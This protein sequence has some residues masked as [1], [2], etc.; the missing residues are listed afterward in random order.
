MLKILM[1][2][3]SKSVAIATSKSYFTVFYM[4]DFKKSHKCPLPT[5]LQF[6]MSNIIIVIEWN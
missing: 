1:Q 5:D 2:I 4:R 6:K 3:M